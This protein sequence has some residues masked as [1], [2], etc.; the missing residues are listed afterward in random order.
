MLSCSPV[1]LPSSA[2]TCGSSISS[3]P[4]TIPHAPTGLLLG[5]SYLVEGSQNLQHT[6]VHSYCLIW[7]FAPPWREDISSLLSLGLGGGELD[8]KAG[9]GRGA[10]DSFQLGSS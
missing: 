8:A 6:P 2:V 10:L 7:N 4:N 3:P 1:R 9:W 5:I